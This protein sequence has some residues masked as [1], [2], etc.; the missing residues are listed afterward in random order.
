MRFWGEITYT[1]D[2]NLLPSLLGRGRGRGFTPLPNGEGLGERLPHLLATKTPV[3]IRAEPRMAIQVV[4][5]CSTRAE[6][7]TVE[8]GFR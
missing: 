4:G 3:R 8:M 6:H 7:T 5:S 2:S 1:L